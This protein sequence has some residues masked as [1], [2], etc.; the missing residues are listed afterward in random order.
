MDGDLGGFDVCGIEGCLT[1]CSGAEGN[2]TSVVNTGR[3]L[4]VTTRTSTNTRITVGNTNTLAAF[5]TVRQFNNTGRN[6]ANANIGGAGI[7]TGYAGATSRAS[8]TGNENG[9]AI[10][11]GMPMGANMFDIVNSGA[12]ADTDATATVNTT[13]DTDNTNCMFGAQRTVS[14][15]STGF[16]LSSRNVGTHTTVSGN[17]GAGASTTLGGND[18]TT[19]IG[20]SSLDLLTMLLML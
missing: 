9:T 13:A 10:Q 16:N 12:N 1:T 6:R 15:N 17:A 8:V 3:N 7:D 2:C 14:A 5:Q 11:V 20:G 18:N 19:V 4:D